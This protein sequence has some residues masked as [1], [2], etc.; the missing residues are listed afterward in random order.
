MVKLASYAKAIEKHYG[1]YMDME[2]AV[3]HQ[4]RIWILRPARKPF[5]PRRIKKRKLEMEKS[6]NDQLITRYSLKA[7]LQA[8]EW[9]RSKCHVITDPKDIDEFQ[10]GEV[11]VTTMTS[12]DWVPAMKRLLPLSPMPAA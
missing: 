4:D 5:G 3:D 6:E 11:L 2:W 1:C 7:F 12:P 10:E 9:Q 8:R